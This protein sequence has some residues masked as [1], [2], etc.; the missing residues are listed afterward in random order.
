[1]S[2]ANMQLLGIKVN[3]EYAKFCYRSLQSSSRLFLR[4]KRTSKLKKNTA[5]LSNQVQASPGATQVPVMLTRLFATQARPA[6]APVV[7]T[8]LG[9]A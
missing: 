3:K 1:M 5:L 8:R 9:V 2:F 7:Q 4:I 6:Q